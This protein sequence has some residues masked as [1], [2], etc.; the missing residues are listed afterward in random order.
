MKF[1][2]R[3]SST[4]LR[5]PSPD[6]A[7]KRLRLRGI[8]TLR[9]VR[10]K[11]LVRNYYAEDFGIFEDE[12]PPK[13]SE[14]LRE[15]LARLRERMRRR[16]QREPRIPTASL[17]GALC[18]L[19]ATA[20]LSGTLVILTL[21]FGYGGPYTDIRIPDF[22]A[23]SADEALS[24]SPELFEYEIVYSK[25]PDHDS[26]RVISQSPAEGVVRRLYRGDG[27]LKVKL[28]VSADSSFITLPET[29]GRSLRD[30]ELMLKNAGINVKVIEEYSSTVPSG[31]ILSSSLAKGTRLYEGD[32]ITLRASLGKETLYVSVPDL[33]SLGEQ[34]AIRA[35]EA[36]GLRVGEVSYESSKSKIG[37]VISQDTATGT[38]LPEGSK[39]SFCVSG[40]LYYTDN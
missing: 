24:V 9:A 16:A 8:S 21:F 31:A 25:N 36:C 6:S 33:T 32:S 2:F 14:R 22:T 13:L 26:G 1:R 35:L 11:S 15:A 4:P 18:A 17:L 29:V 38:T 5:L 27:K 28:T 23:I 7:R 30:T 12:K 3:P 19:L 20:T 34:A 39:V 37:T 40:G 10:Q